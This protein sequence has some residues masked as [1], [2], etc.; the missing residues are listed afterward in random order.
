MSAA[1]GE[2]GADGPARPDQHR[3]FRFISGEIG[4]TECSTDEI[5]ETLEYVHTVSSTL[6]EL[7]DAGDRLMAA[8]REEQRARAHE[9]VLD[10]AMDAAVADAI[11]AQQVYE[12]ALQERL[13]TL[14]EQTPGAADRE[15]ALQDAIITVSAANIAIMPHRHGG[16][17]DA[18]EQ[19]DAE[20]RAD[21]RTYSNADLANNAAPDPL[22]SLVNG[23]TVDGDAFTA[24]VGT[25]GYTILKGLCKGRPFTEIIDGM[26]LQ[27]EIIAEERNAVEAEHIAD[28]APDLYHDAYCETLAE[29]GT[30]GKETRYHQ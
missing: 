22:G 24:Y 25:D 20:K 3:D 19:L 11:E 15:R 4:F 26:A 9:A 6:T 21:L 29:N 14:V 1:T 10:E 8:Y 16:Y 2:V 17:R 7:Q 27:D 30:Y 18:W 5:V 13:D 12:D 23:Y 28:T